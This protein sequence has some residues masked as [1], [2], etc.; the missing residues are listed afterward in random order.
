MIGQEKID[1]RID[2]LSMQLQRLRLYLEPW[3]RSKLTYEG[4][5]DIRK[6][7]HLDEIQTLAAKIPEYRMDGV[8]D[9]TIT[10]IIKRIEA[11]EL[12]D[13]FGGTLITINLDFD[14]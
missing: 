9:A 2:R 6:E 8:E 14:S 3:L 10:E 13:I 11:R 4:Y 5:I 12:E 7:K 1:K